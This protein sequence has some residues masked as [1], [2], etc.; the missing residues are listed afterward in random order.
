VSLVFVQGIIAAVGLASAIGNRQLSRGIVTAIRDVAPGPAGRVLTTAVSQA[1]DNGAKGGIV[2]L[3][4]GLVGTLVSG[5]TAMGQLERGLNRLYGIERD[6]PTS[7]KYGRAFL[8][9]LSAGVL[10][11]VAFLAVGFGPA[12]GRA[13]DSDRLDDIWTWVRWPLAI[14]FLTAAIALLFRWCPNRNQPTWSWLAVGSGIS[15]VL[16]VAVTFLMGVAVDASGSFGDT[17]GPLAGIV[18]LQFWAVLSSIALL[19]GGAVAAQL[20]AVRA[21]VPA[22]A[23]PA[24]DRRSVPVATPTAV[25]R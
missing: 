13:F 14:V 10:A 25:A 21:G 3:V 4:L 23:S 12:I 2:A 18:A 6:R 19:L 24:R 16:W 9:A 8:L 20:E 5:S 15:V 11:A 7:Q 22:A 17:Y 1:R